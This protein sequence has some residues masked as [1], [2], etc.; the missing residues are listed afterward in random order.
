MINIINE[1]HSSDRKDLGEYCI[2]DYCAPINI[3]N[4]F[5]ANIGKQGSL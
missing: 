4:I 3:V 1:Q 2:T 5:T